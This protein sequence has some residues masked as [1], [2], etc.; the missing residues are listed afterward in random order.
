MYKRTDM[1]KKRL[2]CISDKKVR[3]QWGF[4]V[5]YF[6]IGYVKVMTIPSQLSIYVKQSCA[7]KPIAVK[8]TELMLQADRN[9]PIFIWMS[10]NKNCHRV[11]GLWANGLS[12]FLVTGWWIGLILG[13]RLM[14]SAH[15]EL[16][17]GGLD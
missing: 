8:L 12:S 1:L 6:S 7:H 3:Y 11:K 2:I 15:F 9:S 17:V 13:Y 5:Q 10:T 4:A 16:P 14:Y